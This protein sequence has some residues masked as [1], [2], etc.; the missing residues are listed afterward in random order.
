M[1]L[2]LAVVLSLERLMRK[3]RVGGATRAVAASGAMVHSAPEMDP[4]L[5]SACTCI[6]ETMQVVARYIGGSMCR[7]A[8][9]GSGDP[10][11]YGG[12]K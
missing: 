7:C 3:W 2:S 1:N 9:R 8:T 11:L 5:Q 6:S 12:E 4:F 10:V